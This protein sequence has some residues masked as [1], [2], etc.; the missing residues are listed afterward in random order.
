MVI[1]LRKFILTFSILGLSGKDDWEA[2]QVDALSDAYKDFAS[3]TRP[4]FMV[5]F[6]REQGDKVFLYFL[7]SRK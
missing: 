6:G 1:V 3:T 2:A 7:A 5:L 4:Y